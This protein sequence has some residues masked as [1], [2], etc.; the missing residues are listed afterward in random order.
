MR[1]TN[2]LLPENFVFYCLLILFC[3]IIIMPFILQNS[4]N[5]VDMA[6]KLLIAEG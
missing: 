4:S 2:F 5:R 1:E 6:V 3:T